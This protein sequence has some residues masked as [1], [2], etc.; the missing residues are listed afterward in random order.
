MLLLLLY[1]YFYSVSGSMLSL[2]IWVGLVGR[3]IYWCSFIIYRKRILE[4]GSQ[5]QSNIAQL[6]PEN[7]FSKSFWKKFILKEIGLIIISIPLTFLAVFICSYSIL[8]AGQY[9]RSESTRKHPFL[10]ICGI[11]WNPI[12]YI[13][14]VLGFTATIFGGVPLIA[15]LIATILGGLLYQ[16]MRKTFPKVATTVNFSEFWNTRK[17]TQIPLKAKKGLLI[18]AILIPATLYG[19][20]YWRVI[21]R[22]ADYM[23]KMRDGTLLRTRVYFPAQWN[24]EA[25][26]VVLVRTPYNLEGL[27]GYAIN[28]AAMQNYIVVTQDI[29]GT[30]PDGSGSQGKFRAFLDEWS[31]GVDTVNWILNQ[32][33][34]NGKI[35]SHGGSALAINQFCYHAENP[36]GVGAA[37]MI[38][39]TGELYDY[40]FMIGGCFRMG[41]AE[42]W[43]PL[44]GGTAMIE[45]ITQHPLKSDYYQ[46]GSLRINDRYKNVNVRA[47]HI[48]G[49]YD[50][51]CQGTIEGFMLY[52]NASDYAK[53]HQI[54]IMGPWHH[55]LTNEH[56]DITYPQNAQKGLEYMTQTENFIFGEYLRGDIVDWTN[57]PRVYYYIMGDPEAEGSETAFNVW[58]N[59]TN[60]PVAN[61]LE[62]WYFHAD[63][64]LNTTAPIGG[65]SLSFTY[66]PR[67]PV[68]NGGGTT[69]TLAKIGAV[70]QREFEYTDKDFTQHREDILKFTS[71][72]LPNGIEIVG[73]LNAQLFIQSNCTDT[74]FTVKLI[75]VFPDG[76]EM[77]IADGIL[78][79]RYRNG[80]DAE[81]FLVSGMP[82][83]L[84][85]DLWS[86]AYYFAPGHRI[87][88]SITSSNYNKF[89]LNPNTGDPIRPLHVEDL[90][91]GNYFLA[92]NTVYCGYG[93]NDS[94]IWFPR[95]N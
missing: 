81:N 40:T 49:W 42:N 58:R 54:L 94:C 21:P 36:K 92:N 23:V 50:M 16:T 67:N 9:L 34:S 43:L 84:N 51:F 75:D 3:F 53:N 8:M 79:A 29:R 91:P 7:Q 28:Y 72:T 15:E 63:G 66:D 26:P 64:T 22:Q 70:D 77:W 2:N 5:T 73:R 55:G 89:A 82:Y 52:N 1:V 69:L 37:T 4:E 44:V 41:L 31:D 76:R 32:T 59:A 93:G 85:V 57:Q 24:G 90:Q 88:V 48:G 80:Y 6:K 35:A 18:A 56:E 17:W 33:W 65:N 30:P 27:Y 20:M 46:K 47:V 13:L 38:V 14:T 11:F 71:P 83:E 61:T 87:R 60:W 45:E 74:D 39:G 68:L 62:A 25:L 86:T 95:T 78:K 19:L 10:K 12:F